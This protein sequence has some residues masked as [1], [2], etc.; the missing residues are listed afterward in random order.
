MIA[1]LWGTILLSLF[2]TIVSGFFSLTHSEERVICQV[3]YSRD[4]VQLISKAYNY[5]KAKKGYHAHFKN[6]D[7]GALE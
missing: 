3:D 5:H 4:A 7:L 6:R 2:V 1:A